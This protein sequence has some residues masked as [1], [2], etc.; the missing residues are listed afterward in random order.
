[1][2]PTTPNMDWL[3]EILLR[4]CKRIES[5]QRGQ[6][7]SWGDEKAAIT[8]K[9]QQM[10]QEALTPYELLSELKPRPTL[11][12]NTITIRGRVIQ[13]GQHKPPFDY[14]KIHFD[15]DKKR[16]MFTEGKPYDQSSYKVSKNPRS[17][18]YT[19]RSRAFE[20][21]AVLPDGV[22]RKTSSICYDLTANQGADR[23]DE[24]FSTLNGS[25]AHACY[26]P[27]SVDGGCQCALKDEYLAE[28]K[29]AIT[30]LIAEREAAARID[31]LEHI[32]IAGGD[33]Y[34]CSCR[35]SYDI[36]DKEM[37]IDERIAALRQQQ[38]GQQ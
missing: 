20:T 30:A 36:G 15:R 32:S 33:A 10:M 28:A 22:Y 26:C 27:R 3:D 8:T 4:L 14:L 17:G 6:T 29:Q 24:I 18:S 34:P 16:I 25:G 23:L 2:N 7:Y 31:E 12:K 38:K 35:P 1:M 21:A 5:M 9:V 19:I 37:L 11:D 13:F